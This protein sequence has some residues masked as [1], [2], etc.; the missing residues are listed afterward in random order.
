MM[1]EKLEH[2]A[3]QSLPTITQYQPQSDKRAYWALKMDEADAFMNR[4]MNYPV[5]ECNESM[6]SLVSSAHSAGVE[7]AF[8]DKPHIDGL[9]R[10]FYLRQSLVP[11]FIAVAREMN[12]R[13][14]I[15]K[16]EDGY[17]TPAMQRGLG[18]H[19]HIFLKVLN[20][21]RWECGQDIPPSKLLFR[22]L[23]ALVANAPKVGT[24]MSGSA[25]DISVLSR[26]TGE[27]VDRG[28]PYIE[29]SELTPMDSPFVSATAQ[30]NRHQITTLMRRFGFST[31]PWEFW[32]YNA[33]DAYAEE[34]CHSGKPARY[35]AVHLDV[36]TGQV[37]PVEEPTRLLNSEEDVRL[38]MEKILSMRQ[39]FR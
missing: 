22:R 10:L 8:S 25:M 18:L 27:E 32:H 1:I 38:L 23:A 19:E 36:S 4:I 26:D 24:H 3:R 28:G 33:G 29:L 16:V 20:K 39:V 31:Y 14:W 15:L 2:C 9:P 13:G 11:S 7:I 12:D 17:R 6:L 34:L 30:E 21:V 35:G 5:H 37:W